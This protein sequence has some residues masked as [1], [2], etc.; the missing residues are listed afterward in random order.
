MDKTLFDL[1]LE[2]T[3]EILGTVAFS[4]FS[5]IVVKLFNVCKSATVKAEHYLY[6]VS[7][8]IVGDQ[9]L[10]ATDEDKLDLR[11]V[12]IQQGHQFLNEIRGLRIEINNIK[13]LVE[14]NEKRLGKLES[15]VNQNLEPRLKIVED[16]ILPQKSK[17]TK[18]KPNKLLKA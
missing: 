16:I 2:H 9:S 3:G 7:K 8:V 10:L 11:Q 17:T 14:V 6:P 15:H 4:A 12:V 18:A 1:A 5:V 13:G